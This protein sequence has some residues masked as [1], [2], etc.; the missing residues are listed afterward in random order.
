MLVVALGY[1]SYDKFVLD[2]GRD[3]ARDEVTTTA[4]LKSIA[5]LP[6]VAMSSD[7]DD[8]YFADGLTEE[9]LNALAQI[10]DLKV[11]GRTS[12]FQFRGERK[13]EAAADP[14]LLPRTRWLHSP[15][16]RPRAH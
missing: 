13:A 2:P 5:V 1:F 8:G 3:A 7:K 6:F 9:L 15:C 12:S 14:Q 10:K 16:C 11:I 4:A